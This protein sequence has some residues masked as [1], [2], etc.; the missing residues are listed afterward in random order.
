MN[1]TKKNSCSPKL[2]AT[3][4]KTGEVFQFAILAQS[5]SGF[6]RTLLQLGNTACGIETHDKLNQRMLC[7]L[8][9]LS[10]TACGIETKPSRAM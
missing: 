8:L 1:V 5:W 4:E 3:V 10:N 2:L 6:P 7:K 9:Q